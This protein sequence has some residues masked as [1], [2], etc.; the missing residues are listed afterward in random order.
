MIGRQF[1]KYKGSQ[2]K[3]PHWAKFL[4][5]A[6]P[7]K[8]PTPYHPLA[9][10]LTT[11]PPRPTA[12]G[13]VLTLRRQRLPVHGPRGVPV[14]PPR[15]GTPPPFPPG[16]A[17][18][19]PSPT[20]DKP[21]PAPPYYT[22]PISSPDDTSGDN[23]RY[24]PQAEPLLLQDQYWHNTADAYD[25]QDH[26]PPGPRYMT[27]CSSANAT[28]GGNNGYQP[29]TEPHLLQDQYWYH[30]ADTYENQD[31]PPTWPVLHDPVQLPPCHPWRQRRPPA[32]LPAPAAG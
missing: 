10:R 31:H 16:S 12:K 2:E 19:R 18:P 6:A 23:D 28:F 27:P 22:N 14:T 25:N 11:R 8:F 29:Q 26:A 32:S 5:E 13:P 20:V 15:P 24:Q 30:I 1:L 21:P 7:V 3:D 17:T 4:P 9:W